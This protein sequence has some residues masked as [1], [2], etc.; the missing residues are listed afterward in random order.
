MIKQAK[1]FKEYFGSEREQIVNDISE[2]RD[3]KK[4]ITDL[5]QK[6]NAANLPSH[7]LETYV[8][9]CLFDIATQRNSKA[10]RF[11]TSQVLFQIY[12]Y[13][14]ARSTRR[15]STHSKSGRLR[16]LWRIS[17]SNSQNCYYCAKSFSFY[18]FSR[19]LGVERTL[20][21]KFEILHI[22]L[23]KCKRLHFSG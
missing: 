3:V 23:W 18:C 5:K 10:A 13:K 6:L 11:P 20:L 15:P 14:T 12:R 2:K 7:D 22:S 16:C 21:E 17:T 19:P 4:R 8:N 1:D 9:V